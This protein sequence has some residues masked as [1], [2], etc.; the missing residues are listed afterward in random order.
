M[1]VSFMIAV[2][3]KMVVPQA[4]VGVAPEWYQAAHWQLLVGIG[5]TTTTWLAVTF[6]T[7]PVAEETLK[8]FVTLTRPGGPGWSRIN[9]LVIEF[10]NGLINLPT[11][12]SL[13]DFIFETAVD[14]P[15]EEHVQ[16]VSISYI[17][18]LMDEYLKRAAPPAKALSTWN[19]E[20]VHLKHLKRFMD[21]QGYKNLLLEEF[22]VKFFDL[23][24][25]IFQG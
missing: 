8:K 7:Q 3:F 10:K 14:K 13:P 17:T 16:L 24:Y 6:A 18:E 25:C 22:S 2:I 23:C 4:E 12:I 19:T 20:K 9:N 11:G 15:R 21:D 1:I 5:L